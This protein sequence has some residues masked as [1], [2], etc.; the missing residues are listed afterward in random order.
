MTATRTRGRPPRTEQQ[1]AAQRL[2]LTDA[3]MEAIRQGGPELSIDELAIAA[4]V[5]KPVL[6][7]EFGGKLGIADAIA[8]LVAER[9]ERTVVGDLT[10][11]DKVDYRAIVRLIVEGLITLISDEPEIYAFLV[12]SIRTSDRGFLDNALV[13]VI[14]D[15]AI[16]IVKL[17]APDLDSD[18]VS[19]L[20]DGL[21]GFVF[22]SVESWMPL[23]RPPKDEFVD[24]LSAII[25]E[26]ILIALHRAE[27]R[28]D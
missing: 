17:L 15:R 28:S 22:A 10:K 16:L 9:F 20:T 26:G 6:Y 8:V 4:G 24:A 1:R 14:H 21:F 12:R 27:P 5:S 25:G 3:L 19:V 11:I 23:R 7:D 18:S 2:R 13:R